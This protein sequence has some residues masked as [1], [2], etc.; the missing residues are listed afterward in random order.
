M[1]DDAQK[2]PVLVYIHGGGGKSH[3]AHCPRESGHQ[4]ALKQGLCCVNI[5]YRLGIFGFLAHPELSQEDRE[6]MSRGIAA[7]SGNYAI[8]D[9]LCALKWVQC[10]IDSFGGD[11]SNVTIWGLSSGAQYVSTLLVSPA[12]SGL[13]HKAMVQSCADLNNVRQLDSSC[14]VWLGKTAEAWGVCLGEELGCAAGPAGG[15]GQLAALRALP[16]AALVKKT[17][18]SAAKDCYE[19]SI[20]RRDPKLS[21]KPRSSVEALQEGRFPKVPVLLGVTE[22]DGLGKVEL[23]QTLFQ[24]LRSRLE[25]EAL[26]SRNFPDTGPEPALARYWDPEPPELELSKAA[27]AKKVQEA[28]GKL[29]NDLWYFAGSYYMSQLLAQETTVYCY[30]FAGLKHSAH[31]SDA[32]YWRGMP[33]GNLP[34]LMSTYLGNF[35]RS[36]DPNGP[37]LPVWKPGCRWQ[38]HLENHPAMRNLETEALEWYEFLAREYF[39]KVLLQRVAVGTE[40]G[41]C[42]EVK[43]LRIRD[44]QNCLWPMRFLCELSL[45]HSYQG[46]PQLRRCCSA[47][48]W[49]CPVGPLGATDG[50]GLQE[51]EAALALSPSLEKDMPLIWENLDRRWLIYTM[52][53]WLVLTFSFQSFQS[54]Q[55]HVPMAVANSSSAAQASKTPAVVSKSGTAMNASKKLLLLPKYQIPNLGSSLSYRLKSNWTAAIKTQTALVIRVKT[56]LVAA[57]ITDVAE[58]GH[59]LG[60]AESAWLSEARVRLA[61]GTGKAVWSRTSELEPS[62]WPW[63]FPSPRRPSSVAGLLPPPKPVKQGADFKVWWWL[64]RQKIAGEIMETY[65]KLPCLTTPSAQVPLLTWTPQPKT[66][67]LLPLLQLQP[68]LRIAPKLLLM[69]RPTTSLT[70][71]MFFNQWQPEMPDML[72]AAPLRPT[73]LPCLDCLAAVS[74]NARR[75]VQVSPAY[76]LTI[77]NA[78]A[79][80]RK[81]EKERRESNAGAKRL[82]KGLRKAKKKAEGI[83]EKSRMQ[84]LHHLEKARKAFERKVEYARL[85]AGGCMD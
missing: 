63:S 35:A 11:A 7:G 76:P 58:V 41:E 15:P 54:F 65:A 1:E 32:M 13:F 45:S 77:Y 71:R 27:E 73:H 25:L 57:T 47:C 39:S 44:E 38:M 51:T 46:T 12:A 28:L 75:L 66:L 20:D 70:T 83:L 16:A 82:Q 74:H 22:R 53:L 36:G 14:D 33:K 4:L 55:F 9:Q 67:K 49:F 10:H 60:D 24:E 62:L 31:G 17:F 50:R 52:L 29:S 72:P 48:P 61:L 79:T 42:H 8:L 30:C 19:P 84:A 37:D 2:L 26:L 64:L 18:A 6:S 40:P 5:N 34:V 78:N 81:A 80:K 56:R 21:V 23:E 85:A 3:S 43:R 69:I 68:D 59:L